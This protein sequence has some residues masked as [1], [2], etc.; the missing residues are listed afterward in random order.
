VSLGGSQRRKGKSE[1]IS[2]DLD[3]SKAA[4]K[5]IRGGISWIYWWD[6]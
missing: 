4:G 1:T 3:L 5:H 6:Q 2:H